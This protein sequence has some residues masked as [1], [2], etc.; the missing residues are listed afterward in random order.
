VLSVDQIGVRDEFLALGGHSLAASRL[1]ARVI[2]TFRT[3]LSIGTL[4]DS[5][6]VETMAA[7]IAGHLERKGQR[8][9]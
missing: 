9:I 8:W 3:E 6:T 5:S 2:A 4:F 7:V 1:V